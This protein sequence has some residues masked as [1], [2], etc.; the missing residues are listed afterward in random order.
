MLSSE[1]S[2]DQITALS[3][4]TIGMRLKALRRS[5]GMQQGE[6]PS[7]VPGLNRTTLSKIEN[8][9]ISRSRHLPALA[10][11]Y[12]IHLEDILRPTKATSEI[13]EIPK[14]LGA[15]IE[16]RRRAMGYTR[17]EFAQ[18]VGSGCSYQTI[19]DIERKGV[20]SPFLPRIK[21]MLEIGETEESSCASALLRQIRLSMFLSSDEF[22]SIAGCDSN[23]LDSAEKGDRDM[24][25]KLIIKLCIGLQS[26]PIQ[27]QPPLESEITEIH[28]D[29]RIDLPLS[30]VLAS[31]VKCPDG[32][33][34][35]VFRNQ[36]PAEGDKAIIVTMRNTIYRAC[37]GIYR[38]GP[39]CHILTNPQGTHTFP[40]QEIVHM[41]KLG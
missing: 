3:L 33:V 6:V 36:T 23:V 9:Q 38:S 37:F 27:E 7:R 20:C 12:G 4:P 21:A 19:Y 10:D 22:C 5:A 41:N 39:N 2:A 1:Y 25:A 16:K 13:P 8:D 40:E 14:T 15:M 29:G 34:H 24:A 32:S 35:R 31:Q 11:L 26:G 18:E 28:D 30:G 17:K